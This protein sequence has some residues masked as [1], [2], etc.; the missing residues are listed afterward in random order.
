MNVGTEAVAGNW[1]NRGLKPYSEA[2]LATSYFDKAVMRVITDTRSR[3]HME[4]WR[5]IT[6]LQ[7]AKLLL[8]G[9]IYIYIYI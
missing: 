1:Q 2:E 8:K 4:G 7:Y 9:H 6:R 3:T 5:S